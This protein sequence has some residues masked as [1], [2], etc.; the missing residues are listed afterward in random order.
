M[1]SWKKLES[2]LRRRLVSRLTEE[3][4]QVLALRSK[5]TLRKK[6]AMSRVFD[7]HRC[8]SPAAPIIYASTGFLGVFNKY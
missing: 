6:I 5:H 4:R 1:S 3:R 7:N 2:V 8:G